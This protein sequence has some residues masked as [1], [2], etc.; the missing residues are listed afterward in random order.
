V[1]RNKRK[2]VYLED[3]EL[4]RAFAAITD[5]KTMRNFFHEIFTPAEIHDFSLRWQLM[6]ML[7]QGVPQR[8]IA[9]RLRISLCKIT[10]GSKVLKD[11]NA[12]THRYLSITTK[13]RSNE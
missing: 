10:R 4:I 2:R 6:K 11:P 12:V 3:E 13:R 1:H 7:K 9:S 5:E 8:K